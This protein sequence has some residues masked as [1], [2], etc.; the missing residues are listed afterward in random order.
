MD[1]KELFHNLIEFIASV[2]R[3]KHEITKHVKIEEVTPVQYSILE[4]ITVN[5]P[6]TPSQISDCQHMSMPNTSRELKKLVE[7]KLIEKIGDTEDRRK[8]YI[9]LSTHGEIMMNDAFNRIESRFLSRIQNASKGEL[10]E[11]NRAID[12][13]QTKLFY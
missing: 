7:N 9:Q 3:V 8:Q 6:V 10:E 1:K 5:Q 2:H 12:L 13:L 4:Y 11:I